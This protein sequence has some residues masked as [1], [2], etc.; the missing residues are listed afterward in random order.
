MH[1]VGTF[2]FL[3]KFLLILHFPQQK[4]YPGM[5]FGTR[6]RQVKNGLG[7]LESMYA[8]PGSPRNVY[9]K[10]GET[11]SSRCKDMTWTKILHKILLLMWTLMEKVL[12][13]QAEY[14]T[15]AKWKGFCPYKQGM[16][17]S[18][19]IVGLV[20]LGLGSWIFLLTSPGGLWTF[21]VKA[22]PWLPFIS[23][24]VCINWWDVYREIDVYVYWE[25]LQHDGHYW[26]NSPQ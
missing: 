23:C 7:K 14:L 22:Y 11:R 21:S 10:F 15:S 1:F 2:L 19:V 6:P 12:L 13:G 20:D 8:H 17:I 9:T 5:G 24:Q 3:L 25:L 18:C 16:L 26:L 4:H